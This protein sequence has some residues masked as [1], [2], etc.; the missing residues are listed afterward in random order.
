MTIQKKL[1]KNKKNR[2]IKVTESDW[3]TY[4]GSNKD[5]NA[6]IAKLGKNYFTFRIIKFCNGKWDL[7]YS[8]IREQILRDVLLSDNYYNGIINCRLGRVKTK[9]KDIE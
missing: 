7:T 3:K 4:T 9:S 2:Q 8:E 6:D 5:L 1:R